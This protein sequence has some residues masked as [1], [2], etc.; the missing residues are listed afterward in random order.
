VIDLFRIVS[1]ISQYSADDV[2]RSRSLEDLYRFSITLTAGLA[3]LIGH[4][5]FARKLARLDGKKAE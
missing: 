5:T 3:A 2:M 4:R 1:A